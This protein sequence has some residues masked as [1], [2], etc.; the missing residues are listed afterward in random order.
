M[1]EQE[2]EELIANHPNEFFPRKVL[3]LKGRQVTFPG[4]GRFDL[5]FED[6]FGNQILME[7]KARQAKFDDAEQLAR[8]KEA[9]DERGEKNVVMWLVAPRIPK[10]V[11]EFLDRIGVEHSE[12]HE[13]EFRQ[14]AARHDFS[15]ASEKA[16]EQPAAGLSTPESGLGHTSRAR[17]AR[18]AGT[19][20]LRSSLVQTGPKVTEPST[21]HWRAYGRELVLVNRDVF[22]R[23]RFAALVDA[24]E[25]AVPSGRNKKVVADLR[26]W[27]TTPSSRLAIGTYQSLLRWVITSGWKDAVPAAEA[28]WTYLFGRPAPDWYVWRGKYV[29]DANGWE[30]W[31]E[32]LPH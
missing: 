2:M 30:V 16:P 11:A 22:D 21:L 9:L 27:M 29:F 19:Q 25:Q 3:K 28:T 14:V 8:Y 15:F 20:P 4:V 10:H 31:Y 13:A 1:I 24:F 6:Q 5:L 7:L 23:A 18:R 17:T 26:M 12:I 32:S